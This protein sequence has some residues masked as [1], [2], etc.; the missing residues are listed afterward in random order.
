MKKVLIVTYYWPPAGG[1]GV[2][3]CLKITKY[4][5]SFGW[6]PI[7]FTVENPSYPFVDNSNNKDIPDGITILK[8]PVLEFENLFK[9]AVKKEQQS[10]NNVVFSS[11]EKSLLVKL[12]L[13]V[14]ANYF[15]PDAKALWIKPSVKFLSKYLK[16]NKVDAIFS[17]GPPHTNTVIAQKI[18]KKFNIPWLSDYQD[19]WTQVDY[20]D[21]FP[22]SKSSDR[23]HK[24]LERIALTTASKVVS[25]SP[26]FS[27]GLEELGAVNP[28][29]IYYGYDEEDFRDIKPDL[30]LLFTV[31]HAGILASDRL[32]NN[33][34]KVLSELIEEDELFK[35]KFRLKLIGS[36]DDGTLKIIASY[37]PQTNLVLTGVIPRNQVLQQICNTQILL[38][39]VNKVN[40][41]GRIPGKIYEYFRARRPIISIGDTQGD[42]A[43]LIA[44]TKSGECFEYEDYEGL[45][46]HLKTLFKAYLSNDL[47]SKEGQID[48]LSNFNQTKKVAQYLDEIIYDEN[49]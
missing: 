47:L 19:P 12:G 15:I 22:L 27:T 31:V 40:S 45:K 2:L 30:D 48:Y 42:V 25:A 21:K 49:K 34:L 26:S 10:I 33:L 43:H 23:K 29:V 20:Y 16:E 18:A 1:I 13:W 7:I 28:G 24:E 44:E 9:K 5:R 38:N 37:I 32:P 8:C 41:K 39:L 36:V 35:Q 17:D 11:G 14:R 3:R 4:L 6:E 46:K